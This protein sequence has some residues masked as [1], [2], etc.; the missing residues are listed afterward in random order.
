MTI[1]YIS[2]THFAHRRIIEF[3]PDKRPFNT[4]DAHDKV[5]ID[6]WNKHVREDDTVYHLGDVC[7]QPATKLDEIM[8]QLNGRKF[9]VPGNHD[10][11]PTEEYLKYFDKITAVLEDRK[12]KIL[13]SHYPVH[14]SQL[15]YRYEFNVHGHC[16]SYELDDPRYINISCE[17]TGL[18]PIEQKDLLEIVRER[19]CKLT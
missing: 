13:F 4:I 15:E 1:F 5:M 2:D 16:H 17:H 19:K 6:N 11:A 9:L 14:P 3:E 18:A 12:N 7:F 10:L 8:P